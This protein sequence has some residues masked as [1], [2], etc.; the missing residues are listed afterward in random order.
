LTA[1]T[2]QIAY[3]QDPSAFRIILKLKFSFK[4]AKEP[5]MPENGETAPLNSQDMLPPRN[6]RSRALLYGLGITFLAVFVF[7]F[8]LTLSSSSNNLTENDVR[9]IVA[10]AVGTQ[11][12]AAPVNNTSGDSI[13]SDQLQQLV[14]NAVGTQIATLIP[15]STPIPPTPTLIPRGVA[16]DDDPFQGPADAPVVIVEFSDFQ[17]GFCGRWYKETL[18]QILA[19]YP[20]QVKF[21]YRDF[22]IFG[23]E[24]VR[25]AT[26]ADCA[27]EQGKFWEMHNRL[28]DRLENQ[29]NT[30]LNDD[31]FISYAGELGLDTAAFSECLASDRYVN[32]VMADYSAAQKYGLQGTPGFVINGVVYTMGAQ[33]FQVFDTIIQT[34][35]ARVQNEG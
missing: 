18:P 21:V 14:N 28:F 17:C 30:P 35:L 9:Q 11:I 10:E 3:W 32:E 25:A 5:I 29:E 4:V 15:T 20:T 19:A 33:P 16:E 8:L 13:S 34:E 26:A 31:T 12:A 7:A 6:P 27:N 23:Q 2:G 24:S 1:K 22:T